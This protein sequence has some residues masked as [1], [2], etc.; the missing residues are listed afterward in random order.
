MG[1]LIEQPW[2]WSAVKSAR[3]QPLNEPKYRHISERLGGSVPNYHNKAS[4]SR[5]AHMNFLVSQWV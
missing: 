4:I 5:E 1:F 2:N 3:E